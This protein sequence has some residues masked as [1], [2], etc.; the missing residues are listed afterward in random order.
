MLMCDEITARLAAAIA[1]WHDIHSN[2]LRLSIDENLDDRDGD[3]D[4]CSV[5]TFMSSNMSSAWDVRRRHSS[6]GRSLV[7]SDCTN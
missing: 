7:I 4:V 1:T 3:D 5:K 6:G 2:L